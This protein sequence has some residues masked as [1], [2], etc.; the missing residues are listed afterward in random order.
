M[1]SEMTSRFSWSR[2]RSKRKKVVLMIQGHKWRQR[3]RSL[4]PQEP[5]RPRAPAPANI[6]GASCERSPIQHKSSWCLLARGQHDES[7]WTCLEMPQL[8]RTCICVLTSGH[9]VSR[10]SLWF[11]GI[12]LFLLHRA[13]NRS[14]QDTKSQLPSCERGQ[15]VTL[16]RK[17]SYLHITI[18]RQL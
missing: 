4:W 12:W 13:G 1:K 10:F 11:M 6:H 14:S 7:F 16:D 5:Q 2:M 9:P 17:G 8:F 15:N 18:T 3:K